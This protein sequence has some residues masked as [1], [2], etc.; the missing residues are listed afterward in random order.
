M[1]RPAGMWRRTA[2]AGALALA[3]GLAGGAGP[4]AAPLTAQEAEAPARPP[5]P[6][7]ARPAPP[8]PT[9]EWI[10]EGHP[11]ARIGVYL[12]PA[13][14]PGAP[15]CEAGRQVLSL[16]PGGPGERAGMRPGD[17]IL[18]VDGASLDGPEGRKA[19]AD[20]Q[21]GRDVTVTVVR[22]EARLDLRVTPEERLP[23]GFL[24]FE[25]QAPG[26]GGR[27]GTFA[28]RLP[29]SPDSLAF[30]V[31][32]DSLAPPGSRVVFV[33][34]D[35]EGRVRIHVSDGGEDGRDLPPLPSGF[36]V[37]NRELA[38]RLVEA[39]EKAMRVARIRID[40]LVSFDT[41]RR[42]AGRRTVRG[43]E[44]DEGTGGWPARAGRMGG[45]EGLAPPASPEL[46]SLL[47][48]GRRLAGAE[49]RTLDAD[50]AEYFEGA[51]AGLL[52]L[53]VIPGTPAAMLGLRGG[54]VIVRAGGS[55]IRSV[56]DLRRA[57][58][59]AAGSPVAV[60]WVRKGE[61]RSGTLAT[62]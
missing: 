6:R 40:S 55:G 54:D 29:G 20:L 48:P 1:W 57:I 14:A 58:V 22:D 49:F 31:R 5:A 46:E 53:R 62:P 18:A 36:V 28:F 32:I 21:P 50:L 8:P 42:E 12:A 34:E 44:P 25:R 4:L 9:W 33:G 2:A 17:R 27:A 41:G 13:C 37:A 47:A 11:R 24:R 15:G 26:P 52:V 7:A 61:I 19:L 51:E 43:G 10:V 56:D 39:R 45:A 16:L 60:E 23:G 30:T 38:E 59:A 3:A 35:G